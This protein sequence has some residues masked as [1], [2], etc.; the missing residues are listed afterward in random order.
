MDAL[1]IKPGTKI[2]SV[3]VYY[4]GNPI[5]DCGSPTSPIADP[6]GTP[7][8]AKRIYYKNRS[9]P[10]WTTDLDGDFEWQILNLKNGGYKVQ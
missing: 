2:G 6:A 9:V 7:C 8:I 3:I 1:N 5:G 4:E 10:G